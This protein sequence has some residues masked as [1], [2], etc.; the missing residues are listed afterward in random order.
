MP[1]LKDALRFL[2]LSL[3]RE[4]AAGRTNPH[5]FRGTGIIHANGATVCALSYIT[6]LLYHRSGP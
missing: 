1:G 4:G 5:M 2:A 6:P 3:N